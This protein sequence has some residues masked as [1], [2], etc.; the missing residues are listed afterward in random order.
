MDPRTIEPSHALTNATR[1]YVASAAGGL[2][3]LDFETR[4][5]KG[6]KNSDAQKSF[7]SQYHVD[8]KA[9][10]A[11]GLTTYRRELC[12]LRLTP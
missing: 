3:E 1:R 7:S 6:T 9:G 12:F 4:G 11:S 10:D 8:M 2:R 5:H